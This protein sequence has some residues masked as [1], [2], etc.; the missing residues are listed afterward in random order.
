MAMEIT[1]EQEKILHDYGLERIP[2]SIAKAKQDAVSRI[3]K[4]QIGKKGYVFVC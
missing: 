1:A 2:A 3:K 4:H